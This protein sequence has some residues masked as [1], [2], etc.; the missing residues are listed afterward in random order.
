MKPL[1]EGEAYPASAILAPKRIKN[2][3]KQ[4][5]AAYENQSND[6]DQKR[7]PPKRARDSSFWICE[8][9]V[10]SVEATSSETPCQ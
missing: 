4:L 5:E 9:D 10:A 1:M 7:T 2:S 6:T 3:T 8:G